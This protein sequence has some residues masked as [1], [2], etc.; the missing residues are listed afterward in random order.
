LHLVDPW[1]H[2]DEA[3]FQ[4]APYGNKAANGQSGLDEIYIDVLDRFASEVEDGT[5][6]VHRMTSKEAVADFDDES[7]DWVYIDGDHHYAAVKSDLELWYPKVRPGGILSGRDF[8]LDDRW[9]GDGVT[10]AVREFAAESYAPPLSIQ[11]AQFWFRRAEVPR[12]DY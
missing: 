10:R 4:G 3:E 12:Q 9:W 11:N 2:R 8:G 7:V 6:V 1:Q 5:V